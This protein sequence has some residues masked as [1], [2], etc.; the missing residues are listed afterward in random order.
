MICCRATDAH[1][2]VQPLEATWNAGG[3][4]NNAVQRVLVTV[5]VR[6]V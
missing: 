5:S 4:E 2:H 1:G 6:A 3:Y